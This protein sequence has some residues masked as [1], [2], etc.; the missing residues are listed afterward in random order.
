M[1]KTGEE[2][3]SFNL[4]APVQAIVFSENGFWFAATAK[5]Q[6]TVTI[7]DLRKEGDAAQVKV[8]DIGSAVQSLAWD[9][10]QQFLATAGPAGVTVQQYS[11]GSKSWSE[12]LRA[13]VSAVDVKWAANANKLVA[14]NADGVISVLAAKES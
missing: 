14:V 8:L 4:G 7:F 2:A 3:A 12:P 5:G 9:Y 1:T 10:S 6:T 13:A 11:K